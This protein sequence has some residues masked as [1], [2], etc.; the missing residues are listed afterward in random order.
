MCMPCSTLTA[1]DQRERVLRLAVVAQ[2]IQ[3]LFRCRG[4]REE[5]KP[6]RGGRELVKKP[7]H[8]V[9]IGHGCRPDAGSRAIA[10]H[11][12]RGGSR[13]G[14]HLGASVRASPC[15]SPRARPVG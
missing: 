2:S 14:R 9:A 1:D 11:Q 15:R 4:R 8:G 7:T 6:P 10:Q 5:A 13:Y 12:T 3:Q